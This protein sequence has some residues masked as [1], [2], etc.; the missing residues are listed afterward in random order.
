MQTFLLIFFSFMPIFT[1]VWQKLKKSCVWLL[2]YEEQIT[3]V[4]L[5]RTGTNI[6]FARFSLSPRIQLA[7]YPA[8]SHNMYLQPSSPIRWS[9]VFYFFWVWPVVA[10]SSLQGP[11]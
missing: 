1:S 6:S 8:K 11:A 2:P 3:S 5:Y 10:T 7:K 4:D 9:A